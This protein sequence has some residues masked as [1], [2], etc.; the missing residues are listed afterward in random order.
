MKK[1]SIIIGGFFYVKSVVIPAKAGIQSANNIDSRLR[2]SDDEVNKMGP[3]LVWSLF[4][5][6][7]IVL[8][9]K[10]ILK[11]VQHDDDLEFLLQ[12]NRERDFGISATPLPNLSP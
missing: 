9:E 1:P 3:E 11:Q 8:V 10:W 4:Y 12:I 7:S 2:E 6:C 5:M